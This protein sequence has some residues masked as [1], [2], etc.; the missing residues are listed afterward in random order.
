[1]FRARRPLAPALAFLT[2]VAAA[3][4]AHADEPAPSDYC[5][6][7]TAQAQSDAALLFAPSITAQ[8][9]KY[10]ESGIADA[11]GFQVGHGVQPRIAL[12]VGLVDM[13]R[14]V[15][16][17]DVAHADCERAARSEDLEAILAEKD[18][19]GRLP[20]LEH[21]RDY[22]RRRAPEVSALVAKAE[23]RLA[24]RTSTVLEVNELRRRALEI[25]RK[26]NQVEGDIARLAQ[27]HARGSAATAAAI[28]TLLADY[29]RSART[30][31]ERVSHVRSLQPWKLNVSG[32]VVAQ[33]AADVFGLV[34]VVYNLGAI[35]HNA[36]DSRAVEART[37]ELEHARYELR[38]QVTLLRDE[39]RVSADTA[40]REIASLDTH[41]ARLDA[42]RR[43]VA[44]SDAP[45]AGHVAAAL[46]LETI[47]LE[48]D[49]TY[50]AAL[51]D[52]RKAIGGAR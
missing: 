2:L 39:M 36:A 50:L 35:P 1:M 45:N 41:V 25:D 47:E 44:T 27:R 43:T 15:G 33:P 30:Y 19:L 28:G 9:V 3:P 8:L 34:E 42:E 18:D 12:G 7:V 6:K 51:A 31:E 29:E 26:T 4:S 5:R 49:R 46:L 24:A 52:A 22:L 21:E 38:A 32:G 11:A 23:E 20:A 17:L 40:E 14:G 37:Q 13:Y 48:A 10:P 16:V